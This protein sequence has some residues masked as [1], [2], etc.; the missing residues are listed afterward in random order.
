MIWNLFSFPNTNYRQIP[1]EPNLK[2]LLFNLYQSSNYLELKHLIAIEDSENLGRILSLVSLPN[3]GF[4]KIILI[5]FQQD[6]PALCQDSTFLFKKMVFWNDL[7]QHWLEHPSLQDLF[8]DLYGAFSNLGHL[9][10]LHSL[11]C[12]FLH[13]IV[14]VCLFLHLWNSFFVLKKKRHPRSM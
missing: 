10:L 1:W 7:L 9:R 6:E 2:L 12:S 13:W 3:A 4:L 11:L 8:Y 5:V 14:W